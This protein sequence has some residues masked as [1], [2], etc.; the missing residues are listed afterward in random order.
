MILLIAISSPSSPQLLFSETPCEFRIPNH[1]IKQFIITAEKDSSLKIPSHS[2]SLWFYCWRRYHKDRAI[3]MAPVSSL[4]NVQS[5]KTT[6]LRLKILPR[7][8]DL[9]YQRSRQVLIL[10]LPSLPPSSAGFFFHMQCTVYKTI[11]IV[12]QL[13]GDINAFSCFG[14]ATTDRLGRTFRKSVYRIIV[15][16]CYTHYI[17]QSKFSAE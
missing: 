17:V 14:C 8:P 3:N 13:P 2:V 11:P 16:C 6:T 4:A 9:L 15:S 1:K 12:P 10:I 7:H 5:K